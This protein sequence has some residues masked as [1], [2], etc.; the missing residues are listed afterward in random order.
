[1][2]WLA[3]SIQERIPKPP[4]G[5]V[6]CQAARWLSSRAPFIDPELRSLS[7]SS[8]IYY[9]A[10]QEGVAFALVRVE[11]LERYQRHLF[12]DGFRYPLIL[13]VQMYYP[14]RTTAAAPEVVHSDES[15]SY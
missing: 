7:P 4:T 11:L 14:P 8:R 1:M 6:Q 2:T 13:E 5:S 15:V 12:H 3:A 9:W 10:S